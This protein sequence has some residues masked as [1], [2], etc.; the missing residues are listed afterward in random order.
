MVR[1]PLHIV[2]WEIGLIDGNQD[3]QKT[4][5]QIEL[6][7][8]N[9]GE[10][11][12]GT[13]CNLSL[14]DGTYIQQPCTRCGRGAPCNSISRSRNRHWRTSEM[15]AQPVNRRNG[16]ANNKHERPSYWTVVSEAGTSSGDAPRRGSDCNLALA[17]LGWVY[18]LDGRAVRPQWNVHSV[19]HWATPTV[20]Q[21]S[22]ALEGCGGAR[23]MLLGFR[24]RF[25]LVP[26]QPQDTLRS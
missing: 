6:M 26:L 1:G 25:P 17:A 9:I 10:R 22:G 23:P 13:Y 18:E 5:I 8:E 20:A 7:I 24:G 3:K 21:P 4:K 11:D 16:G 2:L 19:S 15:E 12:P 14:V